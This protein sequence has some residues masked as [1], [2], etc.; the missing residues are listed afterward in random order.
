MDKDQI[1]GLVRRT[2]TGLGIFAENAGL[3]TRPARVDSGTRILNVDAVRISTVSNK[4]VIGGVAATWF[5]FLGDALGSTGALAP[6]GELGMVGVVGG[7][8]GS[9][10]ATAPATPIHATNP[11]H[12]QSQKLR[13]VMIGGA[14]VA[15]A[16][17]VAAPLVGMGGHG[18]VIGLAAAAVGAAGYLGGR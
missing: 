1:N 12:L 7:I 8:G 2:G 6:I 14:A 18:S 16:A 10:V 17:T 13:R 9:L 4:T 15:G 5:A 11:L 3:T